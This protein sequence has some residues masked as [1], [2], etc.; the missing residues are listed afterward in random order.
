[1]AVAAAVAAAA[2]AVAGTTTTM[3]G[4]ERAPLPRGGEEEELSVQP[5]SGI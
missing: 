5:A 3:E 4:R 1:M 2:T